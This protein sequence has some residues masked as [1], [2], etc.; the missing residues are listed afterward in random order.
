M[1]YIDAQLFRAI[2]MPLTEANSSDERNGQIRLQVK[3]KHGATNWLNVSPSQMRDI[4]TILNK[5]EVKA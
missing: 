2:P 5:V 1:Q 4:E 3:T